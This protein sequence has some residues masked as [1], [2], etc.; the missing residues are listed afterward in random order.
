M[1]K[2]IINEGWLLVLDFGIIVIP[3]III[4]A[5]IQLLL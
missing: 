1:K 4:L 3:L 5:L 2:P